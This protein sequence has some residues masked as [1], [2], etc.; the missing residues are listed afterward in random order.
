MHHQQRGNPR[1]GG[2]RETFHGDSNNYNADFDFEGSNQKFNKI[3]SEDEF[4][5]HTDGSD[6]PF[7]QIPIDNQ[8]TP[9]YAPLYDKKKS[10]FDNS[11]LTTQS[12]GPRR[13]PY[14]RSNNQNTF[15]YDSYQQRQPN[16]AVGPTYRRA[17]NNNY[18]QQGND[19]SYYRQQNNG[20]GHQYR[21][22]SLISAVMV[23]H[24]SKP[25]TATLFLSFGSFFLSF[26]DNSDDLS[27]FFFLYILEWA[28]VVE[29][30]FFWQ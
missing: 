27:L 21:Y 13:M 17:N 19:E 26:E 22:W 23:S 16:R 28:N 20:N 24:V 1:A 30:L 25:N 15:G 18:R 9:E 8:S 5:Q 14:N 10:F 3:A 11:V 4:K 29:C 7:Q 6:S 12:E 2:N